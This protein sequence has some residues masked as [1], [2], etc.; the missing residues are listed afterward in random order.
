MQFGHP[1]SPQPSRRTDGAFYQAVKRTRAVHPV[2]RTGA[3]D[4][5][6]GTKQQQ[7]HHLRTG[8]R[9]CQQ[10]QPNSNRHQFPVRSAKS[11]RAT[12][13]E[14]RPNFEAGG[15]AICGDA[16]VNRR[17]ERCEVN[18]HC[19]E[20]ICGQGDAREPTQSERRR[21]AHGRLLCKS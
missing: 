4:V 9:K 15:G 13:R 7:S 12:A 6:A 1:K 2:V 5:D 21:D 3:V 18:G 17:C 11:R 14:T 20:R 16:K 10:S 8:C 19:T